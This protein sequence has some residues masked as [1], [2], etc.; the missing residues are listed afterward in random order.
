MLPCTFAGKP[1]SAQMVR[2]VV[3]MPHFRCHQHDS[4]N[5]NGVI[6]STILGPELS[7]KHVCRALGG[8]QV[9]NGTCRTKQ[10]SS[11]IPRLVDCYYHSEGIDEK[12]VPTDGW[13]GTCHLLK[14]GPGFARPPHYGHGGIPRHKLPYFRLAAPGIVR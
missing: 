13:K 4:E 6:L 10:T 3:Q 8:E 2:G 9:E 1:I 12:E 7:M 14:F 11:E 5:R